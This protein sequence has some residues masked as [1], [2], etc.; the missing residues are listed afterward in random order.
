VAHAFKHVK[1]GH[2][3]GDIIPLKASDVIVRPPGFYGVAVLDLSRLDDLVGGITIKGEH[4]HALLV[5]VKR[6]A[7][8]LRKKIHEEIA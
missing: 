3:A 2:Q 5:I 1:T 4:E 7:E 6:A 8:Y